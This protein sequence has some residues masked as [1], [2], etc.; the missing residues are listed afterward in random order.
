MINL[1]EEHDNKRDEE[2]KENTSEIND[3]NE[4]K[5]SKYTTEE[6]AISSLLA[7]TFSL[8]VTQAL[9]FSIYA[10]KQDM[11]AFGNDNKRN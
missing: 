11:I 7:K 10:Y 2:L 9:I 1:A 5:I 6:D 4:S 8:K 3:T